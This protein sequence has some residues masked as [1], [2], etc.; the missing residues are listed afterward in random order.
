[1][2]LRNH[3][4]LG[5]WNGD[6]GRVV[7]I[8]E[9]KKTVKLRLDSGEDKQIDVG[10]YNHIDHGW[11]STTHKAQGATVERAYVFGYTKEP[12]GSQQSTYVQISRGREG[13][14]IYAVAGEK[15]IERPHLERTK[16]TPKPLGASE[17]RTQAMKEMHKSWSKDAAKD[18]TLDYLQERYV[19]DMQNR[20][21]QKSQEREQERGMER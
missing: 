21:Q 19:R 12:M 16:E 4:K 5:V 6:R 9:K 11:A 3:Y 2:L 13:A 10:K 7:E 1:M 20:L 18:T 8:D 14:S 15:S 17:E